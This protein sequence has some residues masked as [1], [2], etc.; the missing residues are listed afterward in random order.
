M[1]IAEHPIFDEVLKAYADC[2][3]VDEQ[4][5][6]GEGDTSLSDEARFEALVDEA[7]THR[8]LSF[9]ASQ[10]VDPKT[11]QAIME[12]ACPG[13]NAFR[14]K[15]LGLLPDDCQVTLAR[16]GSVC[17]YVRPGKSKIPTRS[18]LKA[19]EYSV[20]KEDT[21]AIGYHKGDP[22]RAGCD[23]GSTDYGGYKGEIRIWWD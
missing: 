5:E 9:R 11:A 8:N 12:K 21:F 16:E 15:F 4:F 17:I 23:H 13:Y 10:A 22:S 19:D 20:L 6:R 2:G 3:P 7:M 18:K 14:P 1:D